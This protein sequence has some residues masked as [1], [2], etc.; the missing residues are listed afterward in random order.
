MSIQLQE[1]SIYRRPSGCSII[2]ITPFPFLTNAL[3]AF[4]GYNGNSWLCT[5]PQRVFAR[6]SPFTRGAFYLS[7]VR[8]PLHVQRA[9]VWCAPLTRLGPPHK[10]SLRHRSDSRR[11]LSPR[12]A[13]KPPIW[14]LPVR[15]RCRCFRLANLPRGYRGSRLCGEDPDRETVNS[16]VCTR[17]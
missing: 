2:P 17:T 3:H 13:P 15:R 5:V 6:S 12:K 9:Y 4:Q 1:N 10:P 7:F 16:K 11:R 8:R 14:P